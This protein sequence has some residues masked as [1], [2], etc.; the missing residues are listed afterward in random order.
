MLRLLYTRK[1][2]IGHESEA[3]EYKADR[4]GMESVEEKKNIVPTFAD[5]ELWKLPSTF[6]NKARSY[7]SIC[8]IIKPCTFRVGY[9]L[10]CFACLT[11]DTKRCLLVFKRNF[12]VN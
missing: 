8:L 5:M 10:Q 11:K 6:S 12:N 9:F 1:D 2:S 4:I 3:T 7:K